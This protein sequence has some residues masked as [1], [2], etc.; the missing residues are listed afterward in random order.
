MNRQ[1]VLEGGRLTLRPLQA[2][3]W[4]GLYSVAS[5]PLIWAQHP[6]HDRWQ[7]PVFRAFFNDALADGGALV[8]VGKAGGQIIGSSQFRGYKAADGGSV[9][10]GWTFLSRDHWGGGWNAEMKRLMLAHAFAH[11]ARVEFRIGEDN[12]RSRMA[13]ERIGA[14]LTPRTEEAM[15][16]ARRVVHVV[17]ELTREGFEQGPL[18]RVQG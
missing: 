15:L 5:D 17:Y 12:I 1:P 6:M 14:R 7:E 8:A 13:C 10:I 2:A 4:A 18:M 9:E 3:D 11:V 16:G